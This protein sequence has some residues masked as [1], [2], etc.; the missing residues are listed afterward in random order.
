MPNILLLCLNNKMSSEAML[1]VLVLIS[2][3][4]FVQNFL[5]VVVCHNQYIYI[6]KRNKKSNHV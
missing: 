2:A 5:K 1:F 6:K 4:F 3:F